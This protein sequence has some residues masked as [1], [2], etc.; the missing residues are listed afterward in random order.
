MASSS[1][2]GAS[3]SFYYVCSLRLSMCLWN[4]LKQLHV[5][6]ELDIQILA[7]I[8]YLPLK[9]IT[10]S[11]TCS[12]TGSHYLFTSQEHHSI[13][14]VFKYW[15]PLFIYLS[16]TSQYPTCSNTGSHYLFTSQEHHSILHVFKYWQ[17][18]FIYLSRTSQYPTR[19]QILAAIIYSPLKNI[20]V[21]YMCPNT[22]SH[23]LFTSQELHV[24]KY[25]Q[26]LFIYLS[27][28]SQ[29]PTCLFTSQEHH[30]IL[31]VFKYWQ[32]LFIHLSRTS[33]YP[34]CVQILAAIIY[35]P[36]KNITV[37]YMCSNT[38]SHYLFTSQEHHSIL[39]V[40]KYWQPLFIHLSRTSQYPTC[41]QILAAIIYSP[42][43]NITVS[44]MCPNT[45]SHYLF[46]S[47]EHHSILHVSKYWQ[48]L[49]I[50]LSRT[51]QYPTRVQILAAIIY[52]PLKNITVSYM[53]PNTGSHYLFTSQE[54]HSILHVF[55]CW[56]PLF[57][58]LSRTSQYPTCVQILAA[59]I[60]LPLKNITVSYMC[61]NTGSHYLFT[62]QEHHSILHVSKYWQPLFIY[63]SR[64]SQYP[65][66]VQILAAI[67]YLPLK[68]ITVSYTC[69]N[70]GSHYLFTSQEHHSILH[71]SKYWQPLFIY[72]SRTSQYPTCV[73]ILAAI[74]YLPLKNITVFYMCSNTGSHYLFTSQEHHSILH[75]FKYWQPLF[76]HLSRT[77]Q[78]PTRV[79]ILAA[80]IYS[81]LKNITVSY[82]CSNTGS[83]Y[84][85]A[86]QEQYSILHVFKYWQP[87]FI[88]LSRTSQYPTCVQILAAIIYLPLKNITVSYMCPNTGS[89]YLFT[90]Q[91]HHSILHVSKYW[92]PLFIY[93]SRTSQ[94]PTCVQ[95][96]AAII[97]SPLKN[98]TVSYM[99]SNTGSH[100]LFTSQEHHSI[101]HV[102]KYWQA[103]FIYLS[104][105]SQYPIRVQILA[106]IIYLP[107][108]NITVSYM[109]PNTG[110]HYL[111]TSQEHHSI[112]HVSKYWQ[113]LFIYLSRTSQYPTCV[114][115]LAAI[116]YLPLKN[117]TVSYMCSNTG[118]HYLFTSQEHH[119]ILHVSKYWQPLFIYLSRTS[120]YPTRV[121]ILA[122]IIYLPLKNITV[123]Y[124]CSNTGSHYLFTSQEHHSIL[125]VF[126]YW[127]PLF[128]YLSRTS[129]YPIRVQILAAIIYSPLKN[130]TVSYMCSNTGSHY[131]F[132]S[133][134]HHS[135]LHVFKYW[136]P[137]FIHLSRTSQY[138]TCVQIL[139]LCICGTYVEIARVQ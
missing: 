133:Q 40:F 61:S 96:L 89:H 35:L 94:Y 24:F 48:P 14:H 9:N 20:T 4:V 107:L 50:Y 136:Q 62:S 6:L 27:R 31:H 25:W 83:H 7:A 93:L 129:Q 91:E 60:Y 67:I 77:S 120:Q 127:Q 122:A 90:S 82:T 110:S 41:V 131:L 87:L 121:Q 18:L 12:N 55:K 138:P 28:T 81:P 21:S 43:K 69:P 58:Y 32:P 139:A 71:V 72:L 23:Y 102:F 95:I 126:K 26:P 103:L 73:Q 104:R 86:S 100:Y 88:H 119:S 57:I 68:N 112:L 45:G 46:T 66:C 137:L 22:G 3:L 63:L 108:K 106:A 33:Q 54:H 16:R 75:V 118:S 53:C 65:T 10:V 47:Q 92:Q 70:T 115:I 125:H 116:I 78:Y 123:S 98:I 105:T 51:S 8:I 52:L 49:F 1:C 39:H 113:P 99:C 135:I 44:Y 132:T 34:T 17:P 5:L 30:S 134:E 36:L 56:Q 13:L 109:C 64:T 97:Y 2:L 101:L 124:M 117:I 29:Y 111:F 11:Y 80:I 38:G 74:I 59:I 128:I 130:I 85:F 76:I 114:Q 79:Q 42:L 19:V 15:Q 84:L 37:S